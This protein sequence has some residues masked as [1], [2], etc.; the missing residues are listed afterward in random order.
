MS[1]LPKKWKKTLC[2]NCWHFLRWPV[3]NGSYEDGDWECRVEAEE[4][5][6]GLVLLDETCSEYE[7]YEGERGQGYDCRKH[8]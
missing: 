6:D 2:F 7:E 8:R 4:S 1:S 5:E 3:D